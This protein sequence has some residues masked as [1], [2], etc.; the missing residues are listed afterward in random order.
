MKYLIPLA[1]IAIFAAI[2]FVPREN[3]IVHNCDLAA[4]TCLIKEQGFMVTVDINPKPI[5]PVQSYTLLIQGKDL[6]GM[7]LKAW[8]I[9]MSF[10]HAAEDLQLK[11]ISDQL[12]QVKSNLPF[13]TEKLMTW[14]IHLQAKK[15]RTTFKTNFDFD[16]ARN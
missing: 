8:I 16:V 12:W 9:G 10:V 15:E 11:K 5:D 13:C 6:E 7:E 3:R 1:I 14:R 4:E 2:Y